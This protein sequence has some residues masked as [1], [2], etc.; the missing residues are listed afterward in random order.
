MT[1]TTAYVRYDG[2]FPSSLNA[3]SAVIGF[4]DLGMKIVPFYGFD[5]KS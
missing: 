5:G 4:N 2:E 3:D 1:I